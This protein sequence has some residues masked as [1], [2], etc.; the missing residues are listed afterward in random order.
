MILYL[1]SFLC[2]VV[3]C[4][5]VESFKI[6]FLQFT[7]VICG[8]CC[9]IPSSMEIMWQWFQLVILPCVAVLWITLLFCYSKITLTISRM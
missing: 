8:L 4:E 1:L 6:N 3:W 2:V 5:A 9:N 7:S